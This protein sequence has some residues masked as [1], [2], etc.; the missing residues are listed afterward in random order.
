LSV[1]TLAPSLC[2]GRFPLTVDATGR[3]DGLRFCLA[4]TDVHGLCLSVGAYFADVPMPLFDMYTRGIR[5]E[6]SR[7]DVRRDL[8]EALALA[9]SGRFDLGAIATTVVSWEDAPRAWSEPA[10]KLV[11][12]R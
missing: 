2:V 10:T 11:V 9:A 5:F 6:T 7:A 3:K 8:P 1:T 12:R 4:S